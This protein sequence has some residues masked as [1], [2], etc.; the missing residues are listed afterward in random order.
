MAVVVVVG[1][2]TWVRIDPALHPP[3]PRYFLPEDGDVEATP[4]VFLG[5][6]PARPGYP[7]LLGQV[8]GGFPLPGCYHFRFKTALVPGSDHDKN[9][10]A[11]WMDCVDDQAPVPVWRGAI[12]A[13]VNRLSLDDEEPVEEIAALG[14]GG[15]SAPATSPSASPEM[16]PTHSV[17]SSD[18]LL[19]AFDLEPSPSGV[20]S[21]HSSSGNLLDVDHPT[22]APASGGSLLDL[23]H[24]HVG[25]HGSGANTPTADHHDLLNMSAPV[26]SQGQP[27]MPPG[28]APHR[29]PM[30]GQMPMQYPPQGQYAQQQQ[31]GQYAQQH[32]MRHTAPPQQQPR[33]P[34]NMSMKALHDPLSGLI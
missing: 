13:K 19:G 11:V 26:P 28:G 29:A 5:P 34:T 4:N 32:G 31:Q 2:S 10:M 33:P 14:E 6:A 27:P 22:P 24:H 30:Q 3:S 7:P 12:I 9:A 17:R 23:D 18:S 21:V 20:S 8:R 16:D 15:L 1:R 25:P